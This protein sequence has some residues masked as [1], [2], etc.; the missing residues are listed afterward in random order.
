MAE[1]LASCAN[2]GETLWIP[3][4]KRAP[5]ITSVVMSHDSCLPA[6]VL[7][8]LASQFA[9]WFQYL[10]VDESTKLRAQCV[11]LERPCMG[12]KEGKVINAGAQLKTRHGMMG[13]SSN[14]SGN[15]LCQGEVVHGDPVV[16]AYQGAFRVLDSLAAEWIICSCLATGFK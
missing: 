7:P 1:I 2:H 13:D 11:I 16:D 6:S 12:T 14:N 4:L 5:R 10:K 15:N 3:E 8:L 9:C